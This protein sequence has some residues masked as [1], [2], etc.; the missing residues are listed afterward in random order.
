MQLLNLTEINKLSTGR[1]STNDYEQDLPYVNP[2]FQLFLSRFL[3]L[4]HT[5][6]ICLLLP[7]SA[8]VK[9]AGGFHR[10]VRYDLYRQ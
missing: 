6:S 9:R 5:A 2:K 10:K 3:M 8:F 1:A 4:L 7:A